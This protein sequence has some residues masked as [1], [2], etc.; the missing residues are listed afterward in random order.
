MIGC[1]VVVLFVKQK[2]AYGLR[3]S[4]W[5]ADVCSSDL[6]LRRRSGP[7]LLA[8]LVLVSRSLTGLIFLIETHQGGTFVIPGYMSP[9]TIFLNFLTGLSLLVIAVDNAW[10]RLGEVLEA[11]RREKAVA[12]AILNVAP[13]SILPQG[14]DLRVVKATRNAH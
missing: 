13:V 12:D 2:T 9:L 10:R 11:T 8:G 14:R 7:Y 1:D 6:L 4:D 3:I 5:S